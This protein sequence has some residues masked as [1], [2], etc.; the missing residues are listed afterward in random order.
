M[1]YQIEK[2]DVNNAAMVLGKSF[3]NYPVFSFILP[4]LSYRE[5]KLK[6][7][8]K[9][10]INLGL[11]SG[12]VIATSNKLEGISI[13]IDS[14]SK[15]T[16]AIKIIWYC[17]IPLL[18]RV[19]PV[20]VIRLIKIGR[21]KEKARKDI[22]K[23][24]YNLLDLIGVDPMYQHQGHAHRI[25]ESKLR[26][27]D[28]QFNPCYLETSDKVNISFYEKYN[29]R[30]YHEYQLKKINVYCLLRESKTGTA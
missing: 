17:L 9:F 3:I 20:S 10:L 29:F 26:D 11:L 21:L 18:F 6:F 23:S 8:F 1:L 30:L 27:Y 4:D 12:D 24:P 5:K 13:W 28:N 19:N 14:S 22:L 16:S 15:K 2:K 25:I 7:I